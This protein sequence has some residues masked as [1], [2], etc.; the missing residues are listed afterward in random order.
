MSGYKDSIRRRDLTFM[1]LL[2]GTAARLDEMIF[3]KQESSSEQDKPDA[4]IIGKEQSE[5]IVFTS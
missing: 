2:Y 5:D 1:I 4:T 3:S